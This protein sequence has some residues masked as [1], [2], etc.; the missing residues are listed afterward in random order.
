MKFKIICTDNFA[1]CG[2]LT[3]R[4]GIVDT[5][6]FMPVGTYGTVKSLT[7]Y[8][9]EKIGVQIILGNAF[10]LFIRPGKKIIN[11]HNGLHNFLKWKHPIL[12]DS[13]GFQIFSLKKRSKLTKNGIYFNN[14]INGNIIFFTPEKS[15]DIQYYLKSDISMILDICIGS[16][17]WKNTKK[18]ME[19]SLIWSQRSKNHFNKLK[20]KNF[21]FGIIQGGIYED[22]RNISIKE[23]MDIGFDGYAI[24]GLSVGEKKEDMY[25]II[26]HVST[27]LPKNKPRYLMGVGKPED[28][29]EG[30]KNGIDMFDCVIPTR[31]ARNGHLFVSNGIIKIRNAKYKYDIKNLDVNCNCYTCSNYSRSYLHYLDKCKESLGARLNTIHNLYYYQN[32]MINIRKAIKE[33]KFKQFY[34]NF[35]KNINIK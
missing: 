33:K 29:I 21:I 16:Y 20:N 34:K 17:D 22:L 23:L 3:L 10:H 28:L 31:N 18:F 1:R 32:L 13:G 14:P 15:I 6:V 27:Q 2:K 5:P 35:Y 30:V 8:E 24:G 26:N 4:N 25:R 19:L 9:L 7:T 11:L 12:T